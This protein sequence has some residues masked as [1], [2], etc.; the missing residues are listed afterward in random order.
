MYLSITV[1]AASSG[2]PSRMIPTSKLVPPMS[3]AITL[4]CPSSAA[5]R[6]VPTMP[7]TGPEPMVMIGRSVPSSSGTMPPW[8]CISMQALAEAQLAEPL[9][10]LVQ[11]AAT[12][13]GR[14]TR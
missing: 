1:S 12:C 3:V 14:R 8:H 5:S 13:A 11:V 10:Q 6:C 9:L 7:P 2:S 4:G